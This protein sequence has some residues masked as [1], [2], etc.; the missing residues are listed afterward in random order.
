[1]AHQQTEEL[2]TLSSLGLLEEP[3]KL[4]LRHI[5]K[6]AADCHG[7]LKCLAAVLRDVAALL[8]YLPVQRRAPAGLKQRIFLEISRRTAT[9]WA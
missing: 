2:L 1:M 5:L 8:A 9:R 7:E 3:E 4:V 6:R